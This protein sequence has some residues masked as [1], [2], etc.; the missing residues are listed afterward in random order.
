V[1]S[2]PGEFLRFHMYGK[3]IVRTND[4]CTDF[5]I[6]FGDNTFN[7][8]IIKIDDVHKIDYNPVTENPKAAQATIYLNHMVI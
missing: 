2:L 5:D 3:L 4:K 7:Y 6:I 8:I 1:Q